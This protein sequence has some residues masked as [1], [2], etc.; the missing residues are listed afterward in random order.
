M[1]TY[2]LE[3]DN[4]QVDKSL[5][6]ML[7]TLDHSVEVIKLPERHEEIQPLFL[8]KP[9]GVVFVPSE[10][11]DLFSVKVSQEIVGIETPMEPVIVGSAGD[12][13]QLIVAFNCGVSAFLEVPFTQAV[14]MQILN[15]TAEKLKMRKRQALLAIRLADYEGEGVMASLSPQMRE[16]DI[17]LAKAFV[18]II[19]SRGPIVDGHAKVLLVT[20]S[21]AQEKTL[22]GFLSDIGIVVAS[23]ANIKDALKAVAKDTYR[24][25]ITDNTLPDGDASEFVDKLRSEIKS[26]PRII[27][28]SSSPERIRSIINPDNHIDDVVMKP[29]PGLGV[30]PILPTIIASIYSVDA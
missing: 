15:R 23:V 5:E 30:E 14:L 26:M 11:D 24:L 6:K 9:A 18:D 25:V 10:W 20:T 2:I 7:G 17:F 13:S 8:E 19:K 3:N 21:K 4:K 22:A 27:V 28:W 12:T 1:N 29:S 16:R